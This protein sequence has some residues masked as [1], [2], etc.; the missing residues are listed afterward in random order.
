M[1]F[2]RRSLSR[3]RILR[4]IRAGLG[5]DLSG[6]LLEHI[7]AEKERFLKRARAK[8]YY[9]LAQRGLDGSCF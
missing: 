2:I 1:K 7:R 4:N 8:I 9:A 3:L 5:I 6:E